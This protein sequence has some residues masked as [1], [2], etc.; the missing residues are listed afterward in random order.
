VSDCIQ[1]K[2]LPAYTLT[3]FIGPNGLGACYQLTEGGQY[4]K[5]TAGEME[6]IFDAWFDDASR[7]GKGKDTTW[8]GR[9]QSP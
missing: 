8:I 5:F 6:R 1:V 4:V 7:R 3:R 2:G 9:L